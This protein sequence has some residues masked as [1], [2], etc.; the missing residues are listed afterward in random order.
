MEGVIHWVSA[1][2][3]LPMEVR[4][5]DRLFRVPDP[6]GAEGDIMDYLNDASFE[7]LSSCRV[8]PG[9]KGAA[10]GD[11]YQFERIG[12]FCIDSKDSSPE[13]LVVN[14]IV[15]LRDSWGKIAAGG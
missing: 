6:A 15:P 13:K 3:S 14:R 7:V 10:P 2:H 5:Y 11:R 12:Y 9:L 4:L 1:A 8:E